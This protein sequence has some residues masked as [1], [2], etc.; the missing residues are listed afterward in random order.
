MPSYPKTTGSKG[1]HVYVP[2]V[3]GPTQKEV[4]HVAKAIAQRW[5]K[6]GPT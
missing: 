6:P 2:I 1:I 4:W 5:S 3:R